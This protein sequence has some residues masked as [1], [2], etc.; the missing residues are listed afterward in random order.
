MVGIDILI[1]CLFGGVFYIIALAS[2]RSR[3]G[4]RWEAIRACIFI[5][6]VL[7]GT[8]FLVLADQYP[9]AQDLFWALTILMVVVGSFSVLLLSMIDLKSKK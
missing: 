9:Q 2:V 4:S 1:T 6:C 5:G 3:G 8:L 7:L